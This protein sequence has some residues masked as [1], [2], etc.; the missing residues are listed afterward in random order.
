MQ[1]DP[2]G[3]EWSFEVNA[4]LVKSYFT[5]MMSKLFTLALQLSIISI[6]LHH[7]R[8]RTTNKIGFPF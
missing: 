4:S 6:G 8:Q 3:D 7:R 5:Y 2:E 1:G